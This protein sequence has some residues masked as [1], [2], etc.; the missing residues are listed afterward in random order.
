MTSRKRHWRSI[1]C[2][3]D[4]VGDALVRFGEVYRDLEIWKGRDK[5]MILSRE[6]GAVKALKG[7]DML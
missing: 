4:V 2:V 3:E 1:W 6:V 7:Y 5:V